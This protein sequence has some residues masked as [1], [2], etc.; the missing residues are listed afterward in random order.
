MVKCSECGYE[1]IDGLDYCDGCGAKLAGAAS[2]PASNAG[3]AVAPAPAAEEGS[4]PAAE[5]SATGEAAPAATEGAS[6]ESPTGEISPSPE[7]EPAPAPSPAAGGALFKA[8]LQIVRGGRKGQEFSLEE[9]NNLIGR[10]DPETGSF[11]EVDLEQDDQEAKVSRKHALL[12]IDNGKI[13]VEDIGSLNGTYVNRQPRLQ[14]GNPVELKSGDE[15][16]IGK[17]FLKL[18]VDPIS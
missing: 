10:W 2:A 11:P 3:A 13:T 15:I 7:V 17:T 16:I 4:A 9:A 12:R 14:P 6:P 1:N 18:V 5:V 8:K